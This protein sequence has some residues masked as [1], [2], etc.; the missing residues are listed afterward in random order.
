MFFI[1]VS[2]ALKPFPGSVQDGAVGS[3]VPRGTPGPWLHAGA[4]GGVGGSYVFSVWDF[5][6]CVGVTPLHGAGDAERPSEPGSLGRGPRG[7]RAGSRLCSAVPSGSFGVIFG[8]CRVKIHA[9]GRA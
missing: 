5:C 2:S 6:V 4:A 7:S 8:I 1:S 9:P 3:P